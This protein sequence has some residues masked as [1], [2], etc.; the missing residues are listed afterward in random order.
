MGG[1]TVSTLSGDCEDAGAKTEGA[2]TLVFW[3]IVAL[4]EPGY[5]LLQFKQQLY[6]LS[7]PLNHG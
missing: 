6:G 1:R 3:Y 5:K 4:D 7:S 2:P